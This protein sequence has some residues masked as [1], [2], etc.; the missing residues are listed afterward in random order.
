MAVGS[1]KI[2]QPQNWYTSIIKYGMADILHEDRLV[3]ESI[4]KKSANATADRC[5]VLFSG[6]RQYST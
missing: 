6:N 3:S 2:Y 5:F 4:E 1:E